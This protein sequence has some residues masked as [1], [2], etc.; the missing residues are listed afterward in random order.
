MKDND[1]ERKEDIGKKILNK[2]EESYRIRE[3]KPALLSREI[4]LPFN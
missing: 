4:C 3:N 2:F 1:R